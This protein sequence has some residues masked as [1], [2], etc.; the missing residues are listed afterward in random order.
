VT[1]GELRE[2]CL[3]QAGAVEEFPFGPETSVFKVGGKMFALSRLDA[4]PLSVS[5][6]IDPVL[7]EELRASYADVKPGYHLNKRHWVTI[8]LNGDADDELVRGLIEDSHDLVRPR[9]RRPP[10]ASS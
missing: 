8:D 10:A 1:A 3:S 6:K 2:W 9:R 4:A 5:L 7:G